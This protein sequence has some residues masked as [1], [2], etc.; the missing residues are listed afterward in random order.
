MGDIYKFIILSHDLGGGHFMADKK[1]FAATVLTGAGAHELRQARPDAEIVPVELSEDL[2]REEGR[3]SVVPPP[4]ENGANPIVP[5][6]LLTLHASPPPAPE[7]VLTPITVPVPK[8]RTMRRSFENLRA[9]ASGIINPVTEQDAAID[10]AMERTA[11]PALP[12]RV[13]WWRRFK[14]D[15]QRRGWLWALSHMFRPFVHRSSL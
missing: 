7:R 11:E 9:Y 10:E 2:P 4:S 13:L 15:G 14:M 5:S 6:A 12:L 1:P 3:V 8:R